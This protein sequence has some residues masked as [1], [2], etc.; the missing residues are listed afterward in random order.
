M[1]SQKKKK[2]YNVLYTETDAD[3][4]AFLS[5]RNENIMLKN[6]TRV[7]TRSHFIV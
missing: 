6:E 2:N 1:R 5:I 7:F 4:N 3:V